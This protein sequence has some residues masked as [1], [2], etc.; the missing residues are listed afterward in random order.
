[1][2]REQLFRVLVGLLH[3]LQTV[4]LLLLEYRVGIRL[5]SSG[6]GEREQ[7]FGIFRVGFE[8]LPRQNAC[9]REGVTEVLHATGI[10]YAVFGVKKKNFIQ[11]KSTGQHALSI[12]LFK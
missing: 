8:T 12:H 10:S 2:H 4:E 5:H 3:A 1:M 9:S 6:Q 11:E 7:S